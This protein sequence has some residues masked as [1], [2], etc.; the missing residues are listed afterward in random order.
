MRDEDAQWLAAYAL[1]L[2]V[3]RN[4]QHAAA[5]LVEQAD[6]KAELLELA[7]GHVQR[8]DVG[9]PASRRRATDLLTEAATLA[10]RTLP[11]DPVPGHDEPE[12]RGSTV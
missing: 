2:A 11:P 5:D 10:R 1:G 7:R 9:D 12:D 3:A 4:F 6:G 8:M